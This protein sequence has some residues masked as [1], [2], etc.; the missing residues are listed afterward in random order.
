MSSHSAGFTLGAFFEENDIQLTPHAPEI[1]QSIGQDA[2]NT[3][4]PIESYKTQ[5]TMLRKRNIIIAQVELLEEED[6]RASAYLLDKS[7]KSW[8]V[9]FVLT[10]ILNPRNQYRFS[11]D[12]DELCILQSCYRDAKVAYFYTDRGFNPSVLSEDEVYEVKE[13]ADYMSTYNHEIDKLKK[14]LAQQYSDLYTAKLLLRLE[15]VKNDPQFEWSFESRQTIQKE[16]L[17]AISPWVEGTADQINKDLNRTDIYQGCELPWTVTGM[18]E[19]PNGD[20]LVYVSISKDIKASYKIANDGY[21]F[22]ASEIREKLVNQSMVF[23]VTQKWYF[24]KGNTKRFLYVEPLL[25]MVN[26]SVNYAKVQMVYA[27]KEDIL[28]EKWAES[29]LLWSLLFSIDSYETTDK[30]Y[31]NPSL[32]LCY[33]DGMSTIIEKD[34]SQEFARSII[35]NWKPDAIILTYSRT[36]DPDKIHKCEFSRDELLALS[37]FRIKR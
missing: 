32:W 5:A 8:K 30:A 2:L 1:W 24:A 28:F 10:D 12:G 11:P 36:N 37:A 9:K 7:R 35:V 18:K 31:I 6:H 21:W 27:W 34:F 16:Y 14:Y 17:H 26:A 22:D 25:D 3:P 20:L 19:L 29:S 15:K 13:R 23:K 33:A 4:P